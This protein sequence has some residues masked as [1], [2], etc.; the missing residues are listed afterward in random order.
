MRVRLPMSK[1]WLNGL[2]GLL[3]LRAIGLAVALPLYL[4]SFL[5]TQ[6]RPPIA[7]AALAVS[8]VAGLWTWLE[9]PKGSVH[10]LP[11]GQRWLL[12]VGAHPEFVDALNRSRSEPAAVFSPDGKWW[13]SGST[14]VSNVFPELWWRRYLG[15]PR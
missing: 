1:G 11:T 9:Q 8:L 3:A 5:L 14:W 4:V 7:L 15:S 10:S 12:L 6:S 13:W 2:T